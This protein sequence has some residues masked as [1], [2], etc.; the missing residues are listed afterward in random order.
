MVYC[1][2]QDK[3]YVGKSKIALIRNISKLSINYYVGHHIIHSHP[4]RN[5]TETNG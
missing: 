3:A 2:I 5:N 4:L 1:V